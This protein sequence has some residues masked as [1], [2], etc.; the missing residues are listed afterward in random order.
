MV[1]TQQCAFQ[2]FM[3]KQASNLQVEIAVYCNCLHVKQERACNLNTNG[4]TSIKFRTIEYKVRKNAAARTS[5]LVICVTICKLYK[6]NN[7]HLF[8]QATLC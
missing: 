6:A 4:I 2:L 5:I 7:Q 1:Q 3:H 8:Y